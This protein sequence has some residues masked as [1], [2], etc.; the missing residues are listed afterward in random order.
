MFMNRKRTGLMAAVAVFVM[1][2]VAIVPVMEADADSDNQIYRYTVNSKIDTDLNKVKYIVWDFGDGTVLDGRWQFYEDKK[3]QG[4]TLTAEQE[5]GVAN[6][7]QMLA[8][9]AP[10]SI[11]Q[12]AHTYTQK[13]EYTITVAYMNPV[14]FQYTDNGNTVTFDGELYQDMSTYN[15]GLT[16]NASKDI[17]TPSDA[18][19]TSS[20]F[21]AIAGSWQRYSQQFEVKGYPV[22]SFD[23][24]GGSNVAPIT[25]ENTSEYTVASMPQ[26]NPTKTGY[27][28]NGWYTDSACTTLYDWNQ[29]VKA[30]LVLYAG[31]EQSNVTVYE[32]IVVYMDGTTQIGT[33]NVKNDVNGNVDVKITPVNP[34]KTGKVFGGWIINDGDEPKFKGD[35]VSIPVGTTTMKATWT[36]EV[37]TVSITVDGK[38]VTLAKGKTVADV[39]KPTKDG[40]TFDGWYATS[41][42]TGNKV[43]DTTVLT[44]GMTLF[45]KFTK[46][47]VAEKVKVKVDGKETEFDAGTKVSKIKVPEYKGFTFDGWYNGSVKLNDSDVIAANMDIHSSWKADDVKSGSETVTVK[48]DGKT[49]VVLKGATVAKL[50]VFNGKDK[51]VAVVGD[52]KTDAD[53]KDVLKDGMVLVSEDSDKDLMD[54]LPIILIFVGVVIALIGL[55]IHP[56]VL[57]IGIVIAA[58]GVVMCFI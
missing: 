17:K 25:V 39:T 47:E 19:L 26:E 38:T 40:Y 54:Y 53:S 15:G 13:G 50:D 20:S 10:Q 51:W 21:K 44:E 16:N 12:I 23:T 52:Q 42:L 4:E 46:N 45:A 6:Y 18:D 43:A 36:D 28:F 35:T 34:E 31:W 58:A 41:A 3:L 33:Q 9:N 48:A 32:H 27:E 5:A 57:G 37:T 14:G 30:D 11:A 24:R 49:V 29:P 7:K 55:F 1:L 2:A 8:A 56:I 22:I